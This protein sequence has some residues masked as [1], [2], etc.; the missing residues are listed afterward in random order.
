MKIDTSTIDGYAEMTAE[1]KLAA[2]EAFEYD[3]NSAE[4]ER[5]K[6]ANSKANSEAAEW[7]RKHNAL[8]SEEEQK[9][10]ADDDEKAALL[11]KVEALEKANTIAAYTN[12]YINLGYDK[13][14]AAET[15]KAM[16]E[17]DMTKVFENGEKHRIALEK[18]IKEELMNG[19]PKPDG[20]GGKGGKDDP[21]AAAVERARERAKARLGNT[22][23]Y[24][25]I[26][27]KYKS[28]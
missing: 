26:M 2:L 7:K 4:I 1:Q 22:Q 28:K 21:E 12:S 25:D 9:K 16:Q 10:Q 5:L 3:D 8:L 14:L 19:T 24:N 18:K 6:T 11:A 23:S 15:A 17:G 27:S 20:A 13:E